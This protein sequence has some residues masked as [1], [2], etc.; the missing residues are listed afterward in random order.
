MR[1]A[2]LARLP[3][4]T[5]D[6]ATVPVGEIKDLPVRGAVDVLE[7]IIG[8]RRIR[9]KGVTGNGHG[10]EAEG[11]GKTRSVLIPATGRKLKFTYWL[12]PTN[13]PVVYIV[14]GLGSHRLA[15]P[16]L[17]L[18]ELVYEQGIGDYLRSSVKPLRIVAGSARPNEGPGLGVELD[19]AKVEKYRVR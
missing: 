6:H 14:P 16:A 3:G 18:A 5:R 2:R 10:A 4:C 17:A 11:R 19:D 13:A 8:A 7:P 1:A 9:G 12:Q 15:E